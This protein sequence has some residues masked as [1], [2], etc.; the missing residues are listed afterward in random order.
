MSK[1][2]MEEEDEEDF[3]KIAELVPDIH[4]ANMILKVYEIEAL[5]V[6]DIGSNGKNRSQHFMQQL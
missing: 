5:V 4:Y 1:K 6:Q 3:I 2:D